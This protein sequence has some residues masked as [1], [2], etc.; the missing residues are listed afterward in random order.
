MIR[1]CA[2]SRR[3]TEASETTYFSA[4]RGRITRIVMRRSPAEPPV[5]LRKECDLSFVDPAPSLGEGEPGGAV[6]LRKMPDV[7]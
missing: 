5:K 6:N 3:L 1:S 4:S 7:A 2:L